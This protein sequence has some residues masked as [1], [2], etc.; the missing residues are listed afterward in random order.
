MKKPLLLFTC[1]FITVISFAQT[2]GV[3]WQKSLAPYVYNTGGQVIYG[4]SRANNGG[5]VFVGSDTSYYTSN[6]SRF[7]DK[8]GGATP[9]VFRTDSEG[10]TIWSQ[11]DPQYYNNSSYTSV[12]QSDE[13]E[14]IAAGFGEKYTYQT[15]YLYDFLVAKYSKDGKSVW[16]KSLGGSG[17]E[18]AQSIIQTAGGFVVAGYTNSNDGNVSGNHGTD[19]YDFWVVKLDTDGNLLWQKCYGGSG[20]DKA[21]SV[22]QTS[23][24]GF[25]VAGKDSSANGNVTS[26]KGGFDGWVIKLDKNGD[27]E[28]QKSVGGSNDDCFQSVLQT[29]DG[30]YFLTGYS[31]SNDKDVSANHGDADVWVVRL[32]ASGNI[33]WQN[34]FGGSNKEYG[35]AIDRT[36]DGA[37]L[38]SGFTESNDGDVSDFNGGSDGWLFKVD[39]NGKL[40]WQKT[41]GTDKNEFGT[42]VKALSETEFV[43]AGYGDGTATAYWD[44]SDAYLYKLGNSS[45]IKGTV[46]MDYNGNNAKEANEPYASDV[47]VKTEKN[48]VEQS[49]VTFNGSFQM[50]VDTGTFKTSAVF[51]SPYYTVSPASHST[52]FTSYFNTDSISFAL[53]PIPDK[54]DLSVNLLPLTP[55]RP[56]FAT[57]YKIFYKNQG[58]ETIAAGTVQMIKSDKLEL[59]ST[60]PA[61]SSVSGDTVRFDFYDLKPEETAGITLYFT[62][63]APPAV[64]IGDQLTSVATITPVTADETPYDDTSRLMQTVIGSFDPNDKTENNGGVITPAQVSGADDLLYTIRFQNTGTDTAFNVVVRDTLGNEVDVKSLQMVTSSHNY[65]LNIKDGNKLTW[66]FKNI[67][68]VDSITNEPASHGYIVYRIKPKT[69]LLPGDTIKNTAGIYFDFNLPVS[70]NTARTVVETVTLPVT[71]ISFHA[72]R[73]GKQNEIEWSVAEEMT[74]AGYSVERSSNGSQFKT[75]GHVTAS[76]SSRY[77]FTDVSPEKAINYYR[78]KMT[79]KDG[80]YKYSAVKSVNNSVTFDAGIY[81]NPVKNVVQVKINAEKKMDLQLRIISLDGKVLHTVKQS[82]AAG[83]TFKNINVTSLA[84]GSYFLMVLSAEGQTAIKFEKL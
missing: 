49:A 53:H 31:Y 78:L 47:M 30:G 38:V 44:P 80:K 66:Y 48:G 23:D 32:D 11:R 24:G 46:F 1:F 10:N 41:V 45:S 61:Y 21:Y 69:S 84:K 63:A 34:S 68:L 6:R 28:W 76:K 12:I 82:A 39:D 55:S 70:T 4:M 60:S 37:Y 71:L 40:I 62:V 8:E 19:T 29:S 72:K 79:D 25:V 56:G 22:Q 77:N 18:Y 36:V 54:R 14:F 67:Q 33:L 26:H 5:Y 20:N 59:L 57:Q 74:L 65:Q 81:P 42:G 17:V 52:T 13:G 58:T 73:S 7:I 43:V 64:N 16:S 75:I 35:L 15:G 50:D 9:L 51:Y 2:P 27:L 83:S 3:Q